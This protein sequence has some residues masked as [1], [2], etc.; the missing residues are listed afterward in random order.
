MK[1]KYKKEA[2][3]LD[4]GVLLYG[5]KDKRGFSQNKCL[6][7]NRK[8]VRKK[9]INKT[10]FY[11]FSKAK[12]KLEKVI[13]V[14]GTVLIAIDDGLAI[15]KICVNIGDYNFNYKTNTL[16]IKDNINLIIKECMD[17]NNIELIDTDKKYVL[18]SEQ[19]KKYVLDKFILDLNY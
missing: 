1:S 15:T 9:D 5:Y 8:I 18:L 16:C 6:D 17:A 2:Y 13:L 14:G 3:L 10:L 4:N 7:H 19:S 11:S 12:E